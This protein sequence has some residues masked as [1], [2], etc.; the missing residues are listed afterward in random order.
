MKTANTCNLF[1]AL[2]CSDLHRMIVLYACV[3]DCTSYA[4]FFLLCLPFPKE[5]IEHISSGG[6]S[7]KKR[8]FNDSKLL[9]VPLKIN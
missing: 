1:L 3:Q 4:N 7:T 2:L 5:E 8:N 6:Q 9:L